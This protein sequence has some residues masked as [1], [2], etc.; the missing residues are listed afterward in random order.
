MVKEQIMPYIIMKQKQLPPHFGEDKGMTA[1]EIIEMGIL[2]LIA[3]G[4]GVGF[5]WFLIEMIKV[6]VAM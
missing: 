4:L 5:V 1:R 2:T 6:A 3:V